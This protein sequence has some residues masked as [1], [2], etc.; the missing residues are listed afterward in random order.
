MFSIRVRYRIRLKIWL[1]IIFSGRISRVWERIK[2]SVRIKF[3]IR[4]FS[5]GDLMNL[6]SGESSI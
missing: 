4:I 2:I 6:R 1:R 5:E 3:N